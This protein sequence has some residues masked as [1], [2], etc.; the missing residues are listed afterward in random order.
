MIVLP[1]IVAT[2]ENI[3]VRSLEQ[4]LLAIYWSA[5]YWKCSLSLCV[6]SQPSGSDHLVWIAPPD[7]N[8]I[9]RTFER[10][11]RSPCLALDNNFLM[12]LTVPH[13]KCSF[14]KICRRS[15]FSRFLRVG[16]FDMQL[17]ARSPSPHHKGLIK[18]CRDNQSLRISLTLSLCDLPDSEENCRHGLDSLNFSIFFNCFTHVK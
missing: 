18:F 8:G 3:Y 1:S 10:R 4:S 17:C 13:W 16:L 14:K 5:M 7:M 9:G 2:W 15:C 6:G 12:A 11:I